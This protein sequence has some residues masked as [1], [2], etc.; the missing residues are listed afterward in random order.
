MS[1]VHSP[2]V[3]LR[4]PV[5]W[6]ASQE[7]AE[8]FRLETQRKIVSASKETMSKV[9]TALHLEEAKQ[10]I[11]NVQMPKISL[12]EIGKPRLPRPLRTVAHACP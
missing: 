12:A 6:C 2:S 7:K 5:P 10:S 1:V 11:A 3:R 4:L 9:A 8:K